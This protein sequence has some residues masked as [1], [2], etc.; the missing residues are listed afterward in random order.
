MCYFKIEFDRAEQEFQI[1][2][3]SLSPEERALFEETLKSLNTPPPMN[4][5]QK[6][7]A[8]VHSFRVMRGANGGRQ[9]EIKLLNKKPMCLNTWVI[10]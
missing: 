7:M 2:L 8:G 6:L 10:V 4:I 3:N 1:Y 5:P 9:Y